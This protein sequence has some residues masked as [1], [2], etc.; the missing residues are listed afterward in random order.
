MA[1]NESASQYAGHTARVG[2]VSASPEDGFSKPVRASIRLLAGLGVEGDTHLG[3]TV[4]HRSRV[5]IDPTQPNLRQVHLIHAELFDELRAAGFEIGPGEIG[6]NL[7]THGIDLLTLPRGT[8]LHLGA[9]AVVELTGLRNPCR[10]LDRFRPGLMAATLA[11]TADGALVRK[12]GV[13]A[14]VLN[15]GE[16]RRGDALHVELPPGLPQALERV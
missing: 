3:V 2:A 13:M 6:E 9:Q 11:R 1:S 10:Q 5:A 12:A 8:R 7:T 16:V 15:G 4:Q 14:I